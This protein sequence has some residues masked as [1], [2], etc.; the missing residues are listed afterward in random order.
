MKSVI[1]AVSR[2]QLLIGD[3]CSKDGNEKKQ[4]FFLGETKISYEQ[5][6]I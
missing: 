4:T 5:L 1:Y 2:N 6:S 3:K